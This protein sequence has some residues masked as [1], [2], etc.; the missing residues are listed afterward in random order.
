MITL[1]ITGAELTMIH[2]TGYDPS[3]N[4]C[5]EFNDYPLSTSMI[6]HST[7]DIHTWDVSGY[8]L[9]SGNLVWYSRGEG[10]FVNICNAILVLKRAAPFDP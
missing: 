8:V 4:N 10:P 7:I 9:S 5:L 2:L 1:G 3:C 6:T